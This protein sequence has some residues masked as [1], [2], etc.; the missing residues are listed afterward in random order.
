MLLMPSSTLTAHVPQMPAP[1]QLPVSLAL[2]G[3]TSAGA[4]ECECVCE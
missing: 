3:Y 1:P 2:R 4:S